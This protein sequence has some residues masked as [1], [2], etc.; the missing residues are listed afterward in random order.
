[1]FIFWLQERGHNPG[2]VHAHYRALKAFVRFWAFEAKPENWWDPFK[3]AKAPKV[4]KK[5]LEGVDSD[6]VRSLLETCNHDFYGRRDRAILLI[7]LDTGC[8]AA[9]L[10][11]L[12]RKDVDLATGAVTIRRGK[13]R[14][15]RRVFIGKKAKK[16]LKVYLGARN[17]K[18]G[19]S[20]ALIVTISGNRLSYDGL[21]SMVRRRAAIAG[22][23]PPTLHSFRRAFAL[24]MLRADVDVYTLQRLMGHSSLAVL[25]RYLAQN[26]Q[27]LAEAHRRSSPVDNL[28]K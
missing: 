4:P 9:E 15:P 18:P 8:R 3:T 26:D 7:L 19:A 13:G 5:L 20:G 10:L 21:A 23:D 25:R 17:S 27:D 11:A 24:A 12:D 1:M 28:I 14:K 22:V 6:V 2:G 16:T